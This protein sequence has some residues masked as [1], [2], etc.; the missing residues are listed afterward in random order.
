MSDNRDPDDRNLSAPIGKSQ[1]SH[2]HKDLFD[3]IERG[4][5]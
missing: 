2:L 4:T 1:L 5:I 3:I